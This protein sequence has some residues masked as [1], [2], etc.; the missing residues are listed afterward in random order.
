MDKI[1]LIAH[2]QSNTFT[3]T[4]E[5]ATKLAHFLLSLSLVIIQILFKLLLPITN[6]TII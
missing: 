1:L 6:V 3:R 4:N 5:L 2:W